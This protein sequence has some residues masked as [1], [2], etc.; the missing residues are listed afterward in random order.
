MKDILRRYPDYIEDFVPFLTPKL[1][2]EINDVDG[3]TALCWLLGQF[4][5]LI[6]DAPY[7]LE[8]MIEDLK[9]LQSAELTTVLL[10]SS[11]K[12]FFKRA[13]EMKRIL[14]AIF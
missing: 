7:M 11:F 13:P 4:G 8:K 14:A 10:A 1:A 6:E 5:H 3:K 12:L 2:T 9:E